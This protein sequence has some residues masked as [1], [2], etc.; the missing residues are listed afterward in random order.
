MLAGGAVLVLVVDH[1]LQTYSCHEYIALRV[2]AAIAQ[3]LDPGE[4]SCAAVVTTP[5][6]LVLLGFV[7][8]RLD[9]RKV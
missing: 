9:S 3:P 7:G 6:P 4:G 5:R 1:D 2:P 8:V